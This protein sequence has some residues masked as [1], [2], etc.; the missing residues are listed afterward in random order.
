MQDNRYDVIVVGAGFA[1][2][3]CAHE[4]ATQG[5]R[6]RVIDRKH[7]LG[8]RVHTTGIL[9]QEACDAPL[10]AGLPPSLLRAVPH[11]R[12]YAPNLRSMRLGAD[13]YRFYTTDTPALMRWLGERAEACGVELRRGQAFRDAVRTQTGWAV[14]GVGHTRILVGADGARSRVAQRL[15][16]G[17]VTQFLYGV[18]YEFAGMALREPDALHCFI[19]KRFAPGYLGWV[20]QTPTGVQAGLARRHH[21]GKDPAPD[22]AGFLRHVAPMTGL[23]TAHTPDSIRAGLIP[24][25]GPVRPV[26]RDDV[27]LIGDAAGMV[28]P[29]TAGGIHAG[30]RHGA[31]VGRMLARRL[32]HDATPSPPWPSA[33]P[34]FGFKRL[35]RWAFDHG[36][37]DL[38]VDL[39]LTARPLRRAVEQL[40]FHQRGDTAPDPAEGH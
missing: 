11:V 20:A 14:D 9:V 33:V 18:E 7:D 34:G 22:M 15:G 23:S 17:Q 27:V 35:L 13:G 25:G 1:G 3:A 32:L 39:L 4:L 16:L 21:P 12:L 28:S 24:C 30:L 40:C 2:L 26:Q 5:L 6:I 29:L 8:E 36:Q 37:F 38:P 10:L 31:G 19:S